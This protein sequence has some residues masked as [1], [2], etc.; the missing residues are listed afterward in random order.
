MSCILIVFMTMSISWMTPLPHEYTPFSSW[1]KMVL[2][3][4]L[5]SCRWHRIAISV[6]K[7]NVT[8]ILDC[9]KR[10]TKPLLRSD[11]PVLD[12]KGITV[13]GARLHDEG[14]FQV[15]WQPVRCQ[16]TV[17]FPLTGQKS[18]MCL[19]KLWASGRHSSGTVTRIMSRDHQP[20]AS[21]DVN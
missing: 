10:M 16:K 13:F 19:Y 3:F 12:V 2:L 17:P 14:V 4:F 9:K 1:Y 20:Y 18:I 5:L 8:L 21:K 15:R 7:K 11:K 6:Q